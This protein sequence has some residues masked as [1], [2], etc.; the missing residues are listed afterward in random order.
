MIPLALAMAATSV[1]ARSRGFDTW[2]LVARADGFALGGL[3]A[4]IFS[5]PASL[6]ERVTAVRRG[7]LLATFAA[8]A[9]LAVVISRGYLP[10]FGR[11]PAGSAFSVLGIN[12]LF[13]G[14]VGLTILGAG[15]SSLAWMRRRWLVRV[16]TISYGLYV[17]HFIFL[18]LGADIFRALGARGRPLWLGVL[19]MALAYL[20]AVLSWKYVEKPL[21]DLKRKFSYEGP[22]ADRPEDPATSVPSTLLEERS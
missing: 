9:F 8:I 16:G 17:Y 18:L 12:L 11:P 13:F 2:L 14:L 19:S 20:V 6:G 21:L 22:H 4:A 5:D 7:F 15:R 3:L 1:F 10:R